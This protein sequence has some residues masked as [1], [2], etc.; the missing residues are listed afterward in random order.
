M[1]HREGMPLRGRAI[2][3]AGWRVWRHPL[4]LCIRR[5]IAMS[6]GRRAV[7]PHFH[8]P[9][10][11]E[12]RLPPD[13]GLRAGDRA[14]LRAPSPSCGSPRRRHL[15]HHSKAAINVPR[16]LARHSSDRFA[17]RTVQ[18]DGL[19]YS[20]AEGVV[21][22][23]PGGRGDLPPPPH[24]NR[25]DW[26]VVVEP[27]VPANKPGA[28]GIGALSARD[29]QP[30]LVSELQSRRDFSPSHEVRRVPLRCREV[31]PAGEGAH[32]RPPQLRLQ[33]AR[34][35]AGRREGVRSR[36]F[37]FQRDPPSAVASK[38]ASNA[39]LRILLIN[40]LIRNIPDQ[41]CFLL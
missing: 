37:L 38:G 4:P 11:S 3:M 5:S 26:G 22:H 8:R 39:R 17:K 27:R 13:H 32:Q 12:P 7:S 9:G 20:P 15:P 36:C 23:G 31:G 18:H 6:R 28:G 21:R 10:R 25:G 19:S 14:P 24:P 2:V 29:L 30:P 35:F 33:P 41:C 34:R 1:R 40:E 16:P